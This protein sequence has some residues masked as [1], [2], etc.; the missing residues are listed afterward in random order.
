M[1]MMG[2]VF[3]YL[4]VVLLVL[5]LLLAVQKFIRFFGQGKTGELPFLR[6]HHVILFLGIFSFVWGMFTQLLGIILALNA[7][8]EAA[9]VSPELI[10][11]GLKNSFISPVFGLGTM[12]F[13]ALC[14]AVLQGKHS[15]SGE[16]GD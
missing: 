10:I 14:W 16:A 6:S 4:Q 9:D 15:K 2:G 12:L 13:S 3:F 1:Q 7:I 11:Q 8:I 5:V